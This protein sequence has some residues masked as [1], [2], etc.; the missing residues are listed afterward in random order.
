MNKAVLSPMWNALRMANGIT[1]RAI[2][3]IPKDKL[4]S[5]PIRDMRTPK[6]LVAHMYSA[7]PSIAQGIVKGEIT[8]SD[9]MDK[10][11]CDRIK[12][13]EDLQRF[14]A[15]SWKTADR[16]IQ[17]LTDAQIGAMVKTPWGS[18]FPGFICAAIIYD[19][20]LHH[21]G[22]LYAFLR[23]LGVAPP[24]MWDFEHNAPEFQPQLQQA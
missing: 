18:D 22:Q 4:D 15:D 6:E 2:A 3:E 16:A 17:S 1:L 7:M 13:A 19:E 20:H 8:W 10:V 5:R 11:A 21:R 23:Q 9:E 12:T 14:A 24:F